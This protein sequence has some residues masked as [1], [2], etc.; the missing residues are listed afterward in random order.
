MDFENENR[1]VTSGEIGGDNEIEYSLRPKLLKDYIGHFLWGE[2]YC[3]IKF[4]SS[5]PLI[6]YNYYTTFL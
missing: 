5:S 6:F 3:G 4:H 2:G 1:I